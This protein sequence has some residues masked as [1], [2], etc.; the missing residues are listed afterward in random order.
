MGIS[1]TLSLDIL[2]YDKD[3][4][5]GIVVYLFFYLIA[6][7]NQLNLPVKFQRTLRVRLKVKSAWK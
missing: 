4:I 2:S 3:K 6:L 7:L 1:F 5:G